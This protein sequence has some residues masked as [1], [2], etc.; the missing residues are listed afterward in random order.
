MTELEILNRISALSGFSVPQVRNAINDVKNLVKGIS[1]EEILRIFETYS[2]KKPLSG[3][4]LQVVYQFDR[5]HCSKNFAPVAGIYLKELPNPRYF[6][7]KRDYLRLEEGESWVDK[8]KIQ[9]IEES[10]NTYLVDPDFKRWERYCEVC[11]DDIQNNRHYAVYEKGMSEFK[12]C[13]VFDHV[14]GIDKIRF[15]QEYLDPPEVFVRILFSEP[16]AVEIL[17][18][19]TDCSVK[20]CIGCDWSKMSKMLLKVCAYGNYR[21]LVKAPDVYFYFPGIRSPHKP[22]NYNPYLNPI[23]YMPRKRYI[24]IFRINELE[25]QEPDEHYL[26]DEY[27]RD[28]I[29]NRLPA[30]V[31]GHLRYLG[32]HFFADW[33]KQE[34]CRQYLGRDLPDGYTFVNPYH[35]GES[36][37]KSDEKETFLT[38]RPIKEPEELFFRSTFYSPNVSREIKNIVKYKVLDANDLKRYFS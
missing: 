2:F 31:T 15:V 13:D 20:F 1:L 25:R 16:S 10:L 22:K 18:I 36:L 7:D 34:E 6:F 37:C 9:F 26:D 21:D 4:G 27:T 3:K 35:R 28:E 8:T 29:Y 19:G 32:D 12:L 38:I 11:C 5:S 14:L 17:K 24:S 30:S 23:R 33:I